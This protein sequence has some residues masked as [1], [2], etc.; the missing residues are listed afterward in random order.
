MKMWYCEVV[1]ANGARLTGVINARTEREATRQ[2]RAT[3]QG[4]DARTVS[5]VKLSH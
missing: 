1:L 5:V 2:I 4:R 3:V